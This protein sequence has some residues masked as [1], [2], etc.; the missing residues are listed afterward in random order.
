MFEIGVLMLL[1]IR[2]CCKNVGSRREKEYSD[3]CALSSVR[4]MGGIGFVVV[5]HFSGWP[6]SCKGCR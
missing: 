2:N 1:C 5:L 3:I 6:I 4:C